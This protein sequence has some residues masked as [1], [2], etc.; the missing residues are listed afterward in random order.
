MSREERNVSYLYV[1]YALYALG[2]FGFGI[3][4]TLGG[5]I[6]A[7]AKRNELRGTIYFDHIQFLL[8]TFWI[9]VIGCAIGYVLL[10]VLVGFLILPLVGAWYVFRVIAGFL[11]LRE[12]RSVT[13]TGWLM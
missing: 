3:V 5:V 8:K 7:Y 4:P 11:R 13:P 1:I 9:T 10:F 12:N 2:M 6:M